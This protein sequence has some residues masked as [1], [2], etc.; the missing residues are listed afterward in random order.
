[1]TSRQTSNS[2]TD[3]TESL[4][5]PPKVHQLFDARKRALLA[6]FDLVT[7]YELFASFFVILKEDAPFLLTQDLIH[8]SKLYRPSEDRT[9]QPILRRSKNADT[10]S[11]SQLPATAVRSLIRHALEEFDDQN[12]WT[13]TGMGLTT[14][15]QN[16][17]IS[18]LA[19]TYVPDHA[20]LSE[21]DTDD[22]T[23]GYEWQPSPTDAFLI[24][25]AKNPKL[26]RRASEPAGS[27]NQTDD[28][29]KQPS[30]RPNAKVAKDSKPH[31]TSRKVSSALKRAWLVDPQ[32]ASSKLTPNGKF[33]NAWRTTLEKANPR[34]LLGRDHERLEHN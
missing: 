1:M 5:E 34:R 29:D 4:R 14:T 17:L 25:A 6:I 24:A 7:F 33:R 26:H 18:A 23:D 20:H 16:G 31:P 2:Y 15:S 27:K 21:E 10:L 8:Y 3:S 32:R 28:E 9:K 19:S 13:G 12:H 11:L 22:D 30:A